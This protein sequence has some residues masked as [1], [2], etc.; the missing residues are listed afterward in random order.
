MAGPTPGHDGEDGHLR[1]ARARLSEDRPAYPCLDGKAWVTEPDPRNKDSAMIL[2]SNTPTKDAAPPAS[3]IVSR[4]AG[5]MRRA[6]IEATRPTKADAETLRETLP[7]GT[8]IF[9]SAVPKRPRD[10]VVARGPRD[11]RRGP[12]PR[13]PYRGAL[14]PRYRRGRRP[15]GAA[16]GRSRCARPPRHR[17]GSRLARRRNPRRAAAHRKRRAAGLRHRTCRASPDT[18]TAIRA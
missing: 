17:R 14:L 11:P 2:G 4:I 16:Q 3:D 15:P 8:R 10:E 13:S 1:H 5:F 6:S 7:A 18:R 12:H 9:L